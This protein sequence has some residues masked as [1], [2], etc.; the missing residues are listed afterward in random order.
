M[1][2]VRM[3]LLICIITLAYAVIP[4]ECYSAS[5]IDSQNC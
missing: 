3:I 1:K 4:E 2:T 5:F